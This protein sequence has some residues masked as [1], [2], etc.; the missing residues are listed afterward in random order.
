MSYIKHVLTRHMLY[1][2]PLDPESFPEDIHYSDLFTGEYGPL[3]DRH[4]AS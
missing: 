2:K 1:I 4:K 3:L